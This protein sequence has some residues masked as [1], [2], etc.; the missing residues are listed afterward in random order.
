MATCI[1]KM[2]P[3]WNGQPACDI[4]IIESADPDPVVL[5]WGLSELIGASGFELVATLAAPMA[6]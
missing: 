5:G 2:A 1:A 3:Q 4:G 6:G